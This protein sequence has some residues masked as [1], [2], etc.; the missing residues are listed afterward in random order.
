[1]ARLI[2]FSRAHVSAVERA[3]TPVSEQ[4]VAS[5]DEALNADGALLA[6]LPSVIYERAADRHRN[7][8][9]RRDRA[10]PIET[11]DAIPDEP[12][13]APRRGRSV[14]PLR[15]S[16]AARTPPPSPTASGADISVAIHWRRLLDVFIASERVL[17][18]RPV[19]TAMAAELPI[20]RAQRDAARGQARIYLLREESRWAEFV[21]WLSDNVG[22]HQSAVLWI[23]RGSDLA[24]EAGDRPMVA[25]TLM[26]RSQ[27]ALEHGPDVRAAI[28]LA[29]AAQREHDLPPLVRS[30]SAVR[31]AQGHALLRSR[32]ACA[33][34]LDEAHGLIEHM[35]P[36]HDPCWDTTG[37]H[38]TH[39]YVRA[40]EG[41]CWLQLHEP[42]QAIRSFEQALA[43]WPGTH[44][45]EEALQRVRLAMAHAANNDPDLAAR[46][47][48][49]T[50]TIHRAAP[51]SRVLVELARL[52]EHLAR[53]PN[54]PDVR[55]FRDGF[56]ATRRG[57]HAPVP[58]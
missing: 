22:A 17:G 36:V 49:R 58:E 15:G 7:Q 56:A 55:S 9:R 39:A 12:Q 25:Y 2:R 29:Q 34:K 20:M 1:M 37:T 52:N 42:Q 13:A 5:C 53:W 23:N 8:A 38:C 18:A 28:G 35:T 32:V 30:L 19:I 50:L 4:F 43:S 6:L 47:G 11:G 27:Q 46:Q 10:C 3:Q 14:A 16:G 26:R 57:F 40:Y 51:S 45:A 21:S 48:Q 31:E 41:H 33:R 24:R 54:V 44:R